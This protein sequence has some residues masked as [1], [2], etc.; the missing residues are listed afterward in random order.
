MRTLAAILLGGGAMACAEN[1]PADSPQ[2]FERYRLTAGSDRWDVVAG[3]PVLD[4]LRPRYPEFFEALFSPGDS[5]ESHL[6]RLRDDLESAPASRRNY[7]ALNSVAIAYFEMNY[8]AEDD[9]DSGAIDYLSRS[10]AS[11]KLLAIPWRGYSLVR[12]AALREAILDFFEDAAS[13]RK[14]GTLQ[15]APRLGRIVE[16]LLE[17]EA[18]PSRRARIE[19]IFELATANAKRRE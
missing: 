19:S 17:K 10:F 7:D 8:R 16:S 11:A 5:L 14:P 12:E 18:D 6:R 9:R 15:T 2:N 1:P 3:D 4:D 13:G